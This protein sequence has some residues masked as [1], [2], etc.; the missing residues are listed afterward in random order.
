MTENERQDLESKIFDQLF[1]VKRSSRY[2][3][4][5]R[6]FFELWNTMTVTTAALG[7]LS[8]AWVFQ[9]GHGLP[10]ALI[11]LAV[12]ITG[13]LDLAVGTARRAN[14][15]AEIAREFILL[16]A[17][18]VKSSPSD[19]DSLNALIEKR[20]LIECREPTKLHL[21]DVMC[22]YELLRAMGDTAN[23]P[24]IPRNRRWLA[25]CLSQASYAQNVEAAE[26]VS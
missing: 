14:Q 7:G 25:H 18:F 11:A 1:G 24:Q 16:E 19:E 21:L 10:A 12:S 5:R 23:H 20:L 22:H 13:A 17:M 9:I 26:Q 8:A 3:S 6:R 4:H 2:H 15:H